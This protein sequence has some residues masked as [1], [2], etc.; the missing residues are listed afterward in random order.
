DSIL[1]RRIFDP[2]AL[3]ELLHPLGLGWKVRAQK[4]L[5][6]MDD[7]TPLLRKQAE[8]KEISGLEVYAQ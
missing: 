2:D 7:L 3:T 6:L 1:S 5:E 4:E 8:G